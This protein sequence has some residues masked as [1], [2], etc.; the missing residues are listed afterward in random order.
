MLVGPA[1]IGLGAFWLVEYALGEW[2]G[3]EGR[4]EYLANNLWLAFKGPITFI[5]GVGIMFGSM[6]GLFIFPNPSDHRHQPG[7]SVETKSNL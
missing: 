7:V 6:C 3:G 4:L 2:T 1:L 5:A